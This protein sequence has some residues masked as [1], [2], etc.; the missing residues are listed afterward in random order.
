MSNQSV[1]MKDNSKDKEKIK[2]TY[3]RKMRRY[4]LTNYQ[5]RVP[6]SIDQKLRLANLP[7]EH[8]PCQ[9]PNLQQVQPA[10]YLNPQSKP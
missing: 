5:Y 8:A 7:L 2:P 4:N 6:T 1:S 3:E 9:S 10:N